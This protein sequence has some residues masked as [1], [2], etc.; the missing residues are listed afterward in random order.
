MT[1]ELQPK[2]FTTVATKLY[3]EDIRISRSGQMYATMGY[4]IWSDTQCLLSGIL[5]FT[6]E[7]LD[8]WA[9]DDSVLDEIVLNKLSL[10]RA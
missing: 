4:A 8:P 9:E 6:K 7:E 1:I 5:E 3:L 10:T 2:D